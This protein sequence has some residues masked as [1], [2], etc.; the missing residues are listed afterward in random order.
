MTSTALQPF[1]LERFFARYEFTT[2]YLLCSSDPESMSL[3]ELLA[4]EPGA[5]PRFAELHLGYIDSRGTPELRTAISSLYE[6]CDENQILAHG[7]AEEP[8]YT[9]MHA[10]VEPGDEL[11]VQFPAYQSH[12]SI[13]ESLGAR[14]IRW[15][16]DL[17]RGGAP[18]I[19]ELERLIRPQTRAIVITTPNNPT[20]YQFSR[21]ELDAI[22]DLASEGGIWLFGDEV[23]RGTERE[24]Q[25]LP[26]VCDLYERGVSLGGMAKA[27]GLAGLRIG[28]VATQDGKLLEKL[29]SIK[30]Y[31]TICNSAPGEFLA[32]LALRHARRL[33]DRVKSITSANL[34]L[35]DEFFARRAG[36]FGWTRPRAGTTAFPRYLPGGSEAFCTRLVERAGVLLLPSSAFDAGDA[37]FRIGYGR[38]NCPQALAALDEFM[39]SDRW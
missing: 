29:A 19:G 37:N 9:F 3:R 11:I 14:V 15:D 16:C 39:D 32:A 36:S 30:D 31:L 28:W 17:D 27:Y 18:D 1:A 2:R 33:T 6:R 34:D 7:G 8:I 23:Y 26:A 35:L 38:I 4:L 20:G 25:R 13:A 5:E 10:V 24:A 12:Y 21:A 22:V